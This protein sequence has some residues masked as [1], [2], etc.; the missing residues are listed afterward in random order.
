M[1]T[2]TVVRNR[3]DDRAAGH[4][5]TCRLTASARVH[6][7]VSAVLD[8]GGTSSSQH[9]SPEDTMASS[10]AVEE[11]SGRYVSHIHPHNGYY[12][13]DWS[14]SVERPLDSRRS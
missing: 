11:E 10:I 4:G 1:P 13:G 2:A 8:G 12:A 5:R 6:E 7:T 14:S 9:G 3:Y